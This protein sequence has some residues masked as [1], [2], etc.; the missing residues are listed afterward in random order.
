MFYDE[1]YL[2]L[3]LNINYDI[4]I[5]MNAIN[6]LVDKGNTVVIIEHNIDVINASDYIIDLGPQGGELGGHI[7]FQGPVSDFE[8]CSKSDT[9]KYLKKHLSRLVRKSKI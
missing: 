1:E 6:K 3:I 9:A 8:R 4:N 7:I 5:L 2:F